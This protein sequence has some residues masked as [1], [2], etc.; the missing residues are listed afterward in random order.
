MYVGMDGWYVVCEETKEE[1]RS[2]EKR[3]RRGRE[4]R[5]DFSGQ[6]I[7]VRENTL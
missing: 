6:K 7:R 5:V 1:R 4:T 2:G 3:M